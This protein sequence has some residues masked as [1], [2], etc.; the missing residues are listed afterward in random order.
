MPYHVPE[1]KSIAML[2]VVVTASNLMTQGLNA[3]ANLPHFLVLYGPSRLGK[4]T[5]ASY[6]VNRFRA[7]YVECKFVWTSTDILENIMLDMGIKP[8]GTR[9]SHM[10]NAICKQLVL[11]GR[12]LIIDE[13]DY[14]LKKDCA[15]L[16]RDIHDG[17]PGC[18][19][20]LIG[21]GGVP[22]KLKRWEQFAGRVLGWARAP[23]ASLD[24]AHLLAECYCTKVQ[25]ADDL[26][27]HVHSLCDGSAGRISINLYML[28]GVAQSRGL[29]SMA[30]SDLGD[31]QLYTGSASPQGV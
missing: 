4:S 17:A 27:A 26:I 25:L 29:K 16:V 1:V 19:I 10:L 2:D 12:P 21:M 13:L 8:D 15:D 7:Y 5:S 23:L 22:E 3:P 9:R 30:L 28:E 14:L 11:S 31:T 6:L 20:M 18:T 24:D